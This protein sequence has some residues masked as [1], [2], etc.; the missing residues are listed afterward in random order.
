MDYIHAASDIILALVG[1]YVFFRF[2]QK[3]NLSSTVL[4][5]S[6]VLSVVVSAAFGAM[7]FLGFEKARSISGF[8]E[9]IAT[10]TGGVGLVGAS[11]SLVSKNDFSPLATYGF[12]F[13]GFV[14]FVLFEVG[15]INPILFWTPIIA[16][17][18]V[19]F[20]GLFALMRG[21]FQSGIWLVA[22]VIFFA[23]GSFRKE[24]FGTEPYT[25]DLFHFLMAA[26][27]LSIGMATAGLSNSKQ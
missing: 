25:I 22:G 7:A 14:L 24:F 6:F 15:G 10:I 21:D 16:M 11:L 9:R 17:G 26:G 4:W 23:L 18:L 1:L 12:L 27:L 5:E 8:F 3:L 20:L 19:T 13:A 2:L